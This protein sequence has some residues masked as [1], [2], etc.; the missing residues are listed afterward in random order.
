MQ[1]AIF[2]NTT[3]FCLRHFVYSES[4]PEMR[5]LSP[6]YIIS[7]SLLQFLKGFYVCEICSVTSFYCI[8]SLLIAYCFYL[9]HVASIYSILLLLLGSNKKIKKFMKLSILNLMEKNQHLK[10]HQKLRNQIKKQKRKKIKNEMI[11]T[12]QPPI[13]CYLHSMRSSCTP[14]PTLYDFIQAYAMAGSNLCEPCEI[15]SQKSLLLFNT[16]YS[17]FI[18]KWIHAYI[19]SGSCNF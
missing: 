4:C 2:F 7:K 12:V 18:F 15:A 10:S 17:G 11:W 13:I 8:L 9:Q 19:V 16:F 1:L 6:R 5:L 14:P 3:D